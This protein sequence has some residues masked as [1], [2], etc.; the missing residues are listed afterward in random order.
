MKKLLIFPM[1][2]VFTFALLTSCNNETTDVS[3]TE[4]AKEES[5]LQLKNELM[6][7]NDSYKIQTNSGPSKIKISKFWRKF[8]TALADGGAALLGGDLG[9][10]VAVSELVWKVTEP[11]KASEGADSSL[12]ASSAKN[13]EEN[14]AGDIHNQ[15]I[16]DMYEIYGDTLSTLSM[17]DITKISLEESAKYTGK[18][19]TEAEIEKTVSFVKSMIDA[20]DAEK[21]LDDNIAN[22]KT[23]ATTDAQKQALDVTAV[24]FDGL[25]YVDD[26][27]TTFV[28][29]VT[30]AI[31]ASDLP[32]EMKKSLEQTVSVSDASKK[33]WNTD[34]AN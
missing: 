23:L 4:A 6:I 21:S 33:L 2:A 14:S 7:L 8:W 30:E 1:A 31:Y 22:L 24:I 34:D 3:A 13:V 29:K 5:I 17:E 11:E 27:D 16:L 9:G 20:I 18:T 12:K 32:T 26:S 15:T 10:A 19:Y 25:Q 28:K